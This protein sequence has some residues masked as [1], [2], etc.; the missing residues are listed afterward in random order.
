MENLIVIKL[1][2]SVIT[3]K[4]SMPP[5]VNLKSLRR[6]AKEIAVCGAPLLIVLGGGAHGHQAAHKHGFGNPNTP[7]DRLLL[8]IPDI[9]R[10]MS[11]LASR[12][13]EEL[14]QQGVLGAIFS[15]FNFVTLHDGFIHNFPTEI[16]EQTLNAGISV[17]IHGDVCIDMKKAA[18]ILSGD[19]I[20]VFLAEKFQAKSVFIGTNVDGVLTENP[21]INPDAKHIPLI[22]KTNKDQILALTGPSSSIDVTGGMAKKIS[23][24]LDLANH[25]IDVVIFNLLIP[26]RLT[27]LFLGK[28]IIC[29]RISLN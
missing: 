25:K 26:N 5:R 13:E 15:P 21:E 28:P 10:N 14:S 27:N 23:E 20:A 3:D 12:V 6:I 19:T 16:I 2:G 22:D 24:L 9:R 4:K 11:Q 29:T 1:G 7:P 18:S 8:G 17:I